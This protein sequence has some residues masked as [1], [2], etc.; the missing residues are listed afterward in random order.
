MVPIVK[1]GGR[2]LARWRF[3]S[4]ARSLL[5]LLALWFGASG[6]AGRAA[7]ATLFA[8]T[9]TC[10]GPLERCDAA[11]AFKPFSR[12]REAVRGSVDAATGVEVATL[13]M[14]APAAGWVDV[15]GANLGV[16][17]AVLRSDGRMERVTESHGVARLAAL[18]PGL[19]ADDRVLVELTRRPPSSWIGVTP[20]RFGERDA[21]ER[22]R[23]VTSAT[24]IAIIG[25]LLFA[26]AMLLADAVVGTD[27]RAALSLMGLALAIAVRDAIF[28]RTSIE[29]WT[30]FAPATSIRVEYA[31]V[32][33]VTFSSTAFCRDI[34]RHGGKGGAI[35]RGVRA[36]LAFAAATAVLALLHP[37][38]IVLR[39]AQ[40]AGLGAMISVVAMMV[41]H[42]ATMERR[43]FVALA[44]G[45]GSVIVGAFIDI[46]C[47]VRNVPLLFGTGLVVFGTALMVFAQSLVLALRA[48]ATYARAERLAID[49]R[50][51]SEEVI[52]EHERTAEGLRRI[53]RLKDEF[54]A[55][56]S[57]ELRTPL[58]GILGLV[59][60][61]L[62]GSQ[63]PVPPGVARNLE[64]VHGSA[65]RLANLVN[66]ILDFAKLKEH[67]VALRLGTM[68]LK[69][70]TDLVVRTLE[71]IA[72]DKGLTIVN[73]VPEATFVEADEGRVQQ[74]LVN[75]V[76]N[77]LKFTGQGVVR[78]EAIAQGERVRVTVQDTGV[79]I[80]ADAFGRIFDSFEQVDGSTERTYGGTGLGLAITRRLVEL[81]G[82]KVELS[83]EVGVGSRFSFDLAGALPTT[84][85]ALAVAAVASVASA[86]TSRHEG[87]MSSPPPPSSLVSSSVRTPSIPPSMRVDAAGLR[88]LVVDDEPVNRE[89]LSQH[90]V[91][92]GYE[93]GIARDGREALA[94]L[95]GD[96][97]PDIVLLDV[98]MPACSGYEVLEAL[99]ANPDVSAIPVI[100]LTA[101]ARAEDLAKGFELGA[102]DYLVKPVSLVELEARVGHQVRI[103][104]AQRALASH[105]ESLEVTVAER[106]HELH[107]ALARVTSM[108]EALKVK[109]ED[110]TR[111]L[112]E[113]RR[114]QELTVPRSSRVGEFELASAYWPAGVV[115]GDFVDV[116]PLADR[117][118]RIFLADATGHG[119]QAALRAM[120]IKTLYD[121]AVAHA[122][123]A[124]I[125]TDLNAALVA[126]YPD[127]EAKVDAACVDVMVE[128]H[129]GV[130]VTFAQAGGVAVGLLLPGAFDELRSPGLPLGV[131]NHAEFRDAAVDLPPSSQLVIMSDGVLE[132]GDGGGVFFEWEGVTA[133]CT[134]AEGRPPSET[135]GALHAAWSAHR[136]EAPQDDDATVVVLRRA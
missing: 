58:N 87:P 91:H 61:T 89:V 84:A 37:S 83:S 34:T 124:A 133:A 82:G 12:L 98:M 130:R 68:D 74:I 102:N 38:T 75:L 128:S 85:P 113:A 36:E 21:L 120:V 24:M 42:S 62:E 103:L 8:P 80:P 118:M 106:T 92:Q 35:D 66:D 67:G 18:P 54:M 29:G 93:V 1:A 22:A 10:A 28:L 51:A 4:V 99:R 111:D 70:V 44:A 55:N 50:T 116:R 2:A 11:A 60:A 40:I 125:L 114:F 94:V 108:H 48:A 33:A 7:E 105:A 135:L 59:E 69:T 52:R 86:G 26:A 81:H 49:V 5:V 117:G 136:G 23:T 123:P 77:A 16:R 134:S 110:T 129:G 31:T 79:G 100:L 39:L 72:H 63:G 122:G 73:A 13:A 101:R 97:P 88:V 20:V 3:L 119:V 14:A 132:Q 76:G 46:V 104:R 32:G 112:L 9:M 96:A 56:T 27:R 121:A 41:A 64:L 53:D 126:A 45:F 25:W 57:H 127:L 131:G 90:L 107:S 6:C 71:P 17:V 115:G 43:E 15:E 78:I 65:R 95:L 109:D 19:S 47:N 30:L